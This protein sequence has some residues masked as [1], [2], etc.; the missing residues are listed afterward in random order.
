MGEIVTAGK[1][2]IVDE[3]GF[4]VDHQSWDED[5][6][7]AV[8]GEMKLP[9]GLRDAHW[10]VIRFIRDSF[11][12]RGKCPLVFQTCKMTGIGIQEL[13]S[14]FPTGYLRGACK[15]AG[16]TYKEGYLDHTVIPTRHTVE[17]EAYPEKTY[18]V[19]L[20]GFLVYPDSWDPQW[21][22]YKAHEMN[23]KE[24]LTDR[25]WEIIYFLRDS[26][27][28]NGTVPTVYETCEKN[29]MEIEELERLFPDG[30]HRGAVK[31]SGLRAR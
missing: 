11:E 14:L 15:L 3:Q 22:F 6:A 4:L 29:N 13:K 19:D 1:R 8:S 30:Y 26:F 24:P 17:G 20:R 12:R 25:H 28:E 9:H 27:R 2:F 21:A 16:L 10:K 7:V 18:H 5:F 23:M 31:I